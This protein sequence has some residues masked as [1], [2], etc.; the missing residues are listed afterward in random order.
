MSD[1]FFNEMLKRFFNITPDQM[2]RGFVITDDNRRPLSN[3]DI[4]NFLL[5]ILLQLREMDKK[6][7]KLLER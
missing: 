4:E 7:D 2:T 3:T 5:S 6:I 1:D